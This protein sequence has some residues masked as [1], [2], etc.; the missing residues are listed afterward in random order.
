MS[1]ASIGSDGL[2][3]SS[4]FTIARAAGMSDLGC[5]A[6]GSDRDS[7]AKKSPFQPSEAPPPVDPQLIPGGALRQGR[8]LLGEDGLPLGGEAGGRW[9]ASC[10]R[11]WSRYVALRGRG[12]GACGCRR[13]G[14]GPEVDGLGFRVWSR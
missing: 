1:I 12:F 5:R 2:Q 13:G 14:S 10:A 9:D 3:S 4:A 7:A 8:A 6:H 11:M